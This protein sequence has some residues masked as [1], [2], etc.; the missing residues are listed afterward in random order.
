MR[1][2][3]VCIIYVEKVGF[4]SRVWSVLLNGVCDLILG[5]LSFFLL[6]EKG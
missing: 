1:V 4:C 2:N 3:I 6:I 5:G